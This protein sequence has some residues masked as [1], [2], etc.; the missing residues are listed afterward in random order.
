MIYCILGF[1]AP[2]QQLG[3]G[4]LTAEQRQQLLEFQAQLMSMM[5]ANT[6]QTPTSNHF[7]LK[8]FK[9]VTSLFSKR[10]SA[11]FKN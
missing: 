7:I 1:A 8:Q 6:T 9:T 2:Q 5:N 3:G 11:I 4:Q 10:A